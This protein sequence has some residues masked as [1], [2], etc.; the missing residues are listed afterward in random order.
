MRAR[1]QPEKG[2]VVTIAPEIYLGSARAPNLPALHTPPAP[3]RHAMRAQQVSLLARFE[4]ASGWDDWEVGVHGI[5]ISFVDPITRAKRSATFLPD[6]APEQGW[7]HQQCIDALI[8]KAGYSGQVT[9]QLRQALTL[10][11]YQS[12][13][14]SVTYE[15]YAEAIGSGAPPLAESMA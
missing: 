2:V 7:D 5:I 11:R 14:A 3:F 9:S 15:E 6:V 8:R 1:R 10:E 13:L 4:R 12:T